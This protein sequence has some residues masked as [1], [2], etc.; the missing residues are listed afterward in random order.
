M[1]E[2]ASDYLYRLCQQVKQNVHGGAFV[3]GE[4]FSVLVRRLNTAVALVAEV[5]EENRILRRQVEG[6]KKPQL[7][8]FGGNVVPFSPVRPP[9]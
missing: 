4:E 3:S 9:R 5:E 1:C 7:M 6:N 8:V 2:L